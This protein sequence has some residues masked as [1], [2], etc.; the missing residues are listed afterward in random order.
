MRSRQ[1][2][3]PHASTQPP[4]APEPGSSGEPEVPWLDAQRPH[5]PARSRAQVAGMLA[6]LA[7]SSKCVL[8]LGCGRGRMLVPLARAGH[9]VVGV[10]RSVASLRDCAAALA[11]PVASVRR[12]QPTL[13]HGDM[14]AGWPRVRRA[15]VGH[16]PFH[17]I[18]CLGNTFM[19]IADVDDAVR[20][21]RR[22]RLLLSPRGRIVIDD[23]PG[24][25][26]PELTSGNWQAG[27]SPNGTMQLI[28]AEDDAVFT[29]RTGSRIRHRDWTRGRDC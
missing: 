15:V 29:I 1:V 12:I 8:D 23:L 17:C 2:R 13:V 14:V 4:G 24:E 28:W 20:L 19:L 7:G 9:R 11:R 27:I 6:L 3:R 5:A 10:D 26:W 18:C 16:G 22:L 21:L 25:F